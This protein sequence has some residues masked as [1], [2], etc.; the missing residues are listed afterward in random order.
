MDYFCLRMDS[1]KIKISI[2]LAFYNDVELLQLVLRAIEAQNPADL[3]ILIADDGS[4]E[5]VLGELK[6]LL[7]NCSLPIKHLW[8]PD[9]GFGK[10]VILNKAVVEALGEILIFIDADCVPQSSFIDDH[11][12]NAEAGV[13]LVGRRVN[14]FRQALDR[15]DLSLPHKILPRNFSKLLWWSMKRSVNHLERGVRL[16][17][18][19]ASLMR[20]PGW[21]IVGCNFSLHKKD[22]LAIN[23]FD[24]RHRVHWGAED[25]DLERRLKLHGFR[26]KSL[27]QQ[28]CQIHF[29]ASYFKRRD[30]RS[31]PGANHFDAAVAEGASWTPHGIVK[32]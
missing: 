25:S 3:E 5:Q 26:L 13:C 28:A 29:D 6:E 20:K 15:L 2:I 12:R 23:G 1:K 8:Q 10:T 14:V 21:G 16:P 9:E 4:S 31:A 30:K 19:L 11:L 24:E 27:S 32:C 7:N 18:W 17:S 22:L